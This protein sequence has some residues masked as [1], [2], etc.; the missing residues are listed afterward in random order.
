MIQK[1]I[2]DRITSLK[3]DLA[4]VEF[5]ML[6]QI[7]TIQENDLTLEESSPYLKRIK[8]LSQ[9]GLEIKSLIARLE[10]L[11]EVR[12]ILDKNKS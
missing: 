1:E 2:S 12:K 4:F 5:G 9:E 6:I 3:G 7:Q 10:K 11:S 8:E